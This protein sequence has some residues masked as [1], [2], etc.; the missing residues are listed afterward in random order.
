MC[1]R[2]TLS[3]DAQFLSDYFDLDRVP[4][5]F[6]QRFNIAPGQSI[7]TIRQVGGVGREL[8]F[9]HWG[10]IPS[11]A[12]SMKIANHLI[13][14]RAETVADKPAFRSAFRRKRCLIPADGFYEWQQTAQG[15]QPYWIG[16]PDRTPIGFA[17]LWSHWEPK[18]GSG[19]VESCTILTTTANEQM[20]PYHDRMPVIL[21]PDAFAAWLD[22]EEQRADQVKQ[23]LQPFVGELQIYPVSRD[24]NSPLK[25]NHHLI[26][27]LNESVT[28]GLHSVGKERI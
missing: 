21:Q 6:E 13:N 25:D 24:V 7:A 23:I 26:D 14:A 2:F 16:L 11:W 18:D 10:L 4:A 19:V 28:D 1:G 17:G 3:T 15:K 22:P 8:D 27:R 12:D 5:G 9:T 20:K